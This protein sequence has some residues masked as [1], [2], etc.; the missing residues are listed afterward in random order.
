MKMVVLI[1]LAA[2]I[3]AIGCHAQMM[4]AILV[5]LNSE[6][7][8]V[9][10]FTSHGQNTDA[11][12]VQREA[13]I[14]MKK[15]IADFRDNFKCCPVYFFIDTNVSLV[16]NKQFENV[17][18]GFDLKPIQEPVI[19]A[20]DTNYFV[21]YYGLPEENGVAPNRKGCV[22]LNYKFEQVYYRLRNSEVDQ[23]Y[24]IASGKYDMI[25][26]PI[27]RQLNRLLKNM[28]VK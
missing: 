17:L 15:T 18:L 21:T 6:Q 7:N 20:A 3:P 26:R 19:T 24:A 9:K 1:I 11:V 10:Y 2:I 28:C 14:I 5:Q 4:K 25:Y 13:S 12:R 23:K 8:R 16:K 27:A 22:L